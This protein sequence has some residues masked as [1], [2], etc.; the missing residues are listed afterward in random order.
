MVTLIA[1][2]PSAA[3]D[4]ARITGCRDRKDGYMD[5]GRLAGEPCRVTWTFGHL[6]EI[7]ELPEDQERHWKAENL[8][9]LPQRF[10]LVPRK[11][12]DGKADP[13]V[14]RQLEVI[15]KL[16]A[17]T[18][19][20]VNCGDAG[21]EGEVI[22]RFV[23][24]YVSQ[25]N[26]ACRKP[27]LRLWLSSLMDDAIRDGLSSLR[28]SAEYDGLYLAGK[29]RCE[30]D[31]L[32]G[33]NAT[34]ALTLTVR[35][36]SQG[37][38]RIFSIGRVQTPI[39]A[40]VC[41]RYLENKSFKPEPFWTVRLLTEARG[42]K[43]TVVS[44]KRFSAFGEAES[45]R[46]RTS[47]SLID[48]EAA[49]KTP[50]SV[51]APLLF[52]L[53]SLQQEA[54]RR[55]DMDPDETQAI[56][57]KLYDSKLVT[58]PRTGS[59]YITR[60]VLRTIKDRL[61][62]LAVGSPNAAIRSAALRLTEDGAQL[63]RR[64]VNDSRV[65]D[66]HALLIEKTRPGELPG[67]ERKIYDLIAERM[68]EAF[69]PNCETEVYS[70]RFAC[71]G[72]TFTASS[73]VIVSPGWKAVR[74][75]EAHKPAKNGDEEADATPEQQ[76]PPMQAGDKLPVHKAETVQGQT[77]P[78][79]LYTMDTLMQAIKT[80]G[81]D[82]E[83]DDIKSAL[84]DIGIGTAATRS[85]IIS[86]LK[87]QRK[88]IK[89]ERGKVVPTDTGLEVYNLVKDLSVANPELTGRW[90]I[91]LNL[92]AE[93]RMTATDFD[94]KIRQY[95]D[96]ITRKILAMN[97]GDRMQ[98]A[99]L[100]EN[101][102]CPCCGSLVKV[103]ETNARCTNPE[104]GLSMSRVI[105]GKK[106]AEPTIKIFLEKGYTG[107][108]R[109]F[110]SKTGKTFDARLKRVINEKEGRKYANAEFVFEGV[111]PKGYEHSAGTPGKAGKTERAEEPKRAKPY[112]K[113]QTRRKNDYE[114]EMPRKKKSLKDSNK[115]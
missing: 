5:G 22:Q 26:P 38:K 31:W 45:L 43:F 53:A 72:E 23:H 103:W 110:T 48:V 62:V 37:E 58:Y 101:I 76:L 17:T 36:Q 20:I 42:V 98:K 39:L 73:T 88:F 68:V 105:C 56:M 70:C 71:S 64:S 93:G 7:A 81:R 1:E 66:H 40:L 21:R 47:E 91:A 50:K 111:K 11:G 29:A 77:K 18:D 82:S 52:D 89:K 13:G 19:R 55:Y 34:E 90:E 97:I 102:T 2:K 57:Q 41:R 3:M 54:S 6:C 100:A 32:V 16:F 92:I 44:E 51:A 74:G 106:L 30:A 75:V 113:D 108:I 24:E 15:E 115:F 61:A 69:S 28:P 79:P 46:R 67:K 114:F 25:R 33:I 35:G 80:A 99:A 10:I 96:Q 63:N 107:V 85:A 12:K 112:P 65:T 95:T 14:V 109:G 49:E 86:T 104:C 27:V 94:G 83:D 4:L 84:K 9:V 8:P 59:Q 60:D 87:D 78:K